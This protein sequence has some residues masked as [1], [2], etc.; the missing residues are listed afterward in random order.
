MI[1]LMLIGLGWFLLRVFLGIGVSYLLWKFTLK[2][3]IKSK[4][5]L[6]LATSFYLLCLALAGYW[7]IEKPYL[8]PDINPN[9]TELF[10][11]QGEFPFDMG[12]KLAVSTAGDDSDRL[13]WYNGC[14]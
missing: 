5:Q 11:I 2:R 14:F 6:I 3:W 1:F 10:T 9:P 8:E 4:P 12:Y 13:S 7:V